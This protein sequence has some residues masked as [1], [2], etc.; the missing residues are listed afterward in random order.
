MKPS[1]SS[2]TRWR[3]SLGLWCAIALALFITAPDPPAPPVMQDQ[4]ERALLQELATT[5]DAAQRWQ[6]SFGDRQIP[7]ERARGHLAIVIDDVGRELHYFEQ[8]LALRYALTFSVL[9]GSVYA[10]GVQQRLVADPRRPREIWL[11]LPCEPR[12]PKHMRTPGERDEDFL[13]VSDAPEVLGE[14]LT[15]ALERVPLAIGVNNHMGSR[16]TAERAAMDALMPVLRAR[17]LLFL[18]SLTIGRSQAY[19]AARDA[20]VPAIQRSV[21]LDHEPGRAK[22]AARLEEAA[23]LAVAKPT[24]V[25]GHPSQEVVD[26]LRERL[27]ELHARGIGVYPLA[28][29]ITRVNGPR[30]R[31]MNLTEAGAPQ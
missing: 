20:G 26:V 13:R 16:L 8:L 29:V 27:P 23:A 5:R 18:D 21:F 22:I 9:P 1:E 4:D 3:L 2:A 15:R 14:K 25:I 6:A 12:D 31:S 11:H 10:P 7:W 30:D 24:V 17:D 19:A 28:E